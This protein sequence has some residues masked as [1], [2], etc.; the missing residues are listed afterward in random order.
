MKDLWKIDGASEADYDQLQAE[1]QMWFRKIAT[2]GNWKMPIDA[3]I[4]AAD[5]EQCS[6]AAIWFTGAPLVVVAE[7]PLGRVRVQAPGYYET[8]GA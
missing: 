7:L 2:V 8:I 3:V 6:N 1:R 4:D 5:L